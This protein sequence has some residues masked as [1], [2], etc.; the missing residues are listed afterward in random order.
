[1]LTHRVTAR[2]PVCK[3]FYKSSYQVHFDEKSFKGSIQ[4]NLP[5]GNKG[6]F[7]LGNASFW[8][9]WAQLIEQSFLN[10]TNAPVQDRN[11]NI[12]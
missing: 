11:V 3:K 10:F 6:K 5:C 9:L 12:V 1:M 2:F 7:E 8:G 4:Q